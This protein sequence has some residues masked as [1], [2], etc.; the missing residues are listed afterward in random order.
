MKNS[1]VSEWVK[2]VYGVFP[3]LFNNFTGGVVNELNGRLIGIH[4]ALSGMEWIQEEKGGN[5]DGVAA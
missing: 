5:R 3:T 4:S 2:R 1:E